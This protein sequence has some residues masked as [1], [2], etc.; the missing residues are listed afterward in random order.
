V[1]VTS[2]G[3]RL[4]DDLRDVADRGV[5]AVDLAQRALVGI[6]RHL[7]VD[8][9]FIAAVD[10][11]TLLFTQVLCQEQPLGNAQA[12]LLHNEFTEADV[13]KFRTVATAH[14]P[15]EWLNRA[16]SGEWQRSPRYRDILRPLGFGDEL[17]LAL[18]TGKTCWAVMCLH[19]TAAAPAFTRLEARTLAMACRPLAHGARR[20]ALVRQIDAG[21][22]TG[23]LPAL[24]VLDAAGKVVSRSEDAQRWLDEIAGSMPGPGDRLPAPVRTVIAALHGGRSAPR[25]RLQTRSG[26]WLSLHATHLHGQADEQVAVIIEPAVA[27]EIAPIIVA[28]YALTGRESDVLAAVLRG[29]SSRQI[30]IALQISEHTVQDHLKSIF[31]KTDVR[32]RAELASRVFADHYQPH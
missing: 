11:T 28:A 29:C 16:T 14:E 18:R 2:P 15:V 25:L 20:C 32:S 31:T 6:R 12:Q 3:R 13:A 27:R 8:A 30:A 7:G 19:R 17:R 23:G 9:A 26:D 10:P 22:A 5:D 24:L 1:A 4:A 21:R